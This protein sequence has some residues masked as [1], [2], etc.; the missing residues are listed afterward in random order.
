MVPKARNLC[1]GSNKMISIQMSRKGTCE[2][3]CEFLLTEIREPAA[4]IISGIRD[5][6]HTHTHAHMHTHTYTH[7]YAYIQ[8]TYMCVGF[9]ITIEYNLLTLSLKTTHYSNTSKF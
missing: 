6:M 5:N 1:I 4:T 2:V 7:L 3:T 8:S 9:A